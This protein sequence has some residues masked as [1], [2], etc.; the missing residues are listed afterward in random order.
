MGHFGTGYLVYTFLELIYTD[1]VAQKTRD[2]Y[3]MY[4]LGDDVCGLYG[5]DCIP[6][7]PA[8]AKFFQDKFGVD[9]KTKGIE[10]K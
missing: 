6:M 4:C 7:H 9:V 8:A 10:V 2:Q 3:P 1:E 5:A